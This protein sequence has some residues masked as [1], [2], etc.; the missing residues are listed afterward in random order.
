MKKAIKKAISILLVAVIIFGAAPLAGF[1]GLKLPELN[2][3][4]ARAATEEEEIPTSGTCGDN[5]TW[6]FDEES[7][8][9]TIS[10]TG[11]MANYSKKYKNGV[12]VTTA[13]WNNCVSSIKSVRISDGVTSIGEYAFYNCDG[14]TS[15]T[16]PDSVTSAGDY[17]FSYCDNLTSITIPDSVTTIGDSA[18][19]D[20]KLENVYYTGSLAEWCAIEFESSKA[21]PMVY[22]NNIYIDGVLFNGNLKI[23]KEITSI[24]AYAFYGCDDLVTVTLHSGITSIGKSAF[25]GCSDLYRVN[26]PGTIEQWQE[27]SGSSDNE[28]LE[29]ILVFECN[30]LNPYYGGY[31]GENLCWKFHVNGTELLI[32]GTGSMDN[33]GYTAVTS[34]TT[35]PWRNRCSEIKK[36]TI[37]DGATSIGFCAFLNCKNLKSVKLPDSLTYI[38]NYAFAGCNVLANVEL[39]DSLTSIGNYAFWY[40]YLI[41]KVAI[42]NG[43]VTIGEGAFE[44]CSLITSVTIPKSVTSIDKDAFN[45]CS[46][47]MSVY[48]AGSKNDWEEIIIY[49]GNEELTSAMIFYNSAGLDGG[50]TEVPDN[51]PDYDSSVVDTYLMPTPT[52]T[53]ISYGDSIVLHV[54]PAKIPE[55]GKVEW[56]PSNGNFSYSVSADGTTCTISPNKSGDTTFT[57]IVYDAEGN[58]V[59]ADKQ[60]MTSKAG[61]F[62]KIIAFFKKLFGL[63]KTIPQALKDIY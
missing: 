16:I 36:I 58:I 42:P 22:A 31:C 10:G 28:N 53:T 1:V 17:A 40:C 3:I 49:G 51:T 45:E 47:I 35:A 48:Y 14:I 52:E 37:A 8:E 12:N 43:V 60:E 7:G 33:F 18:F 13:P 9:L 44:G 29:E 59:S 5:L 46:N 38:G 24:S 25:N 63:T 62:D 19:S 30:S 11:S 57:A 41:T 39:P 23:P 2:F 32:S 6:E 54:D 26:Y 34:V 50:S 21:N 27:V 56:Y 15:I 61:F 55:G 4:K 20:T